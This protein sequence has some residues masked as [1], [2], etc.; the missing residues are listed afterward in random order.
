MCDTV[1]EWAGK[2]RLFRLTFGGVL[3]LEQ[4]IGEGIGKIFIRLS[5]SQFSAR[6]VYETLRLGLIGGGMSVLDAKRL[7]DAH[8]ENRPGGYM[9]NAMVAASILTDLMTGVEPPEEDG[10]KV[11]ATEP[12]RFSEISQICRVFNISPQELRDMRYADFVNLVKGFNAASPDKVAPH[13]SEEEFIDILNKY[14]PEA[15]Q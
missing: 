7:I 1:I 13:I 9:E 12:Y 15:V 14:E 2:E 3:D 11:D 4:A 6:E 5:S 8:F 10:E